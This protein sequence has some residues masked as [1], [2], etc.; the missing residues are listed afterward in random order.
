M[1]VFYLGSEFVKG[2]WYL[3]KKVSHTSQE[4]R[5]CLSASNSVKR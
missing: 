3:E 1:T 4:H 2:G 5:N